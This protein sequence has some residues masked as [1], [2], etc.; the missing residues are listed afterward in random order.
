MS[1]SIFWILVLQYSTH[2]NVL[3]KSILSFISTSGTVSWIS[4]SF[5][6]FLLFFFIIFLHLKQIHLWIWQTNSIFNQRTGYLVLLQ[7]DKNIFSL[8]W[9]KGQGSWQI[10]KHDY[11][12][13]L[14]P[15]AERTHWLKKS[16]TFIFLDEV[17]NFI[18]LDS[19][20][21]EFFLVVPK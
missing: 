10:S 7:T 16:F 6:F 1:H 19:Y 5:S 18:Y 9:S 2:K 8:E 13:S 14:K 15:T 20:K 21:M 11:V 3:Y 17:F 4:N 12:F